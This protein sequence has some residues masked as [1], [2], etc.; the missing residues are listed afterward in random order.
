MSSH[1]TGPMRWLGSGMWCHCVSASIVTGIA[2]AGLSEA[3]QS[4]AEIR[5]PTTRNDVDTYY[6]PDRVQVIHL[7]IQSQDLQKMQ[8]ALP[9]RVYMPATFQWG[10]VTI[11]NVGMRYKGNS[12]SIPGQQHKRGYLIKFNEYTKGGT[13]LGLHRVALDNGVQ[14]GSL[15][16]EPLI[17][18]ILRDL[19]IVA[20]RC[21]FAKLYVNGDYEGV[22]VN[23]E[24]IDKVFLRNHFSDGRG[25]LYKVDEGGA[26]ADWTP[27]PEQ[28][29]A[30]DRIKLA[31]EPQSKTARRDGRD[32]RE[33]IAR[34]NLTPAEE[35][36]RVMETTIEMD[37]FL[38]TMAV[39]LFSGAF[40]QLTG[41]NPHNYCL[42]HEP[43]SNRW[44]YLP[45]DLDVGFADNAF[46]QI[47]VLSGWNA[48]WPIPGGPPRPLIERIVD[49]PQLLARY[50]RLADKVLEEHFRPD[51]LLPRI[52]ALYDLIKGD[53]EDDPFP[54]R[55]VTNPEDRDYESIVASIKDFVRRRYDTA[56]AQLDNPGTRPAI[57]RN[58]PRPEQGPQPGPPSPDAPSALHVTACSARS[59]TLQWTDNAMGAAVC[60]VQRA[61]GE[62]GQEFGN[63]IGLPGDDVTEATDNRVTPGQTYRYR[64]Y[65]IRP[66]PAGPQGTGVSNTIVVRVPDN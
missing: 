18:G 56:R 47:P 58:S 7:R 50:R 28:F 19:G 31:F 36:A 3:Q 45:F 21:N 32:V 38:Q 27:L 57:V 54:H 65:A 4:A 60:I 5:R 8:A 59:V 24:R 35:F 49:D 34:V 53:L 61:V 10:G 44:H 43:Q 13:F 64:V 37:A 48:A 9:E 30:T 25:A 16:S 22:Y 23:V 39:L 51:I 26:G 1:L 15:F 55:R 33:L 2:L 66:T 29:E 12:S 14:F 17:T 42:Y 20:P 62:E 46:G 11:D 63:H 40:D 52:D 41:W 6:Q